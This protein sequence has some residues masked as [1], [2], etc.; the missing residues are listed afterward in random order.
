MVFPKPAASKA[1]IAVKTKGDSPTTTPLEPL[2]LF[3]VAAGWTTEAR[4][5]DVSTDSDSDRPIRKSSE[6]LPCTQQRNSKRKAKLVEQIHYCDSILEELLVNQYAWPFLKPVDAKLHG[7]RD[8]Y[9]VITHPMDMGTVKHRMDNREYDNPGEFARDMRLI[10]TNCYKYHPSGHELVA[11]ANELQRIFELRYAKMPDESQSK[12]RK[13][14]PQA[15]DDDADSDSSWTSE[16]SSD[17]S[18]S[19]DSEDG[20]EKCLRRLQQLQE[21]LHVVTEQIGR[22]AA[23]GRKQKKRKRKT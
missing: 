22:L 16:S 12:K 8:Y 3:R 15:D 23:G 21:Q 13:R 1:K 4:R 9:E 2:R 6:R 5:P 19:R 14:S 20:E 18:P 7:L 10:F 11:M 17:G